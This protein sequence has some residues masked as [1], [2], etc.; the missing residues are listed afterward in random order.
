MGA[1]DDRDKFFSFSSAP[2]PPAERAPQEAEH[3]STSTHLPQQYGLKYQVPGGGRPADFQPNLPGCEATRKT[4]SS[5]R[6]APG[7]RS[8]HPQQTPA[9]K[10]S[11]PRRKCKAESTVREIDAIEFQAAQIP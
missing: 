9:G 11:H 2:G 7:W 4:G 8:N 3:K 6:H 10:E 1:F 5:I